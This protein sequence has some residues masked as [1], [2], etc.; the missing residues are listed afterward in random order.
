MQVVFTL[1]L[2]A[3]QA[4]CTLV[5]AVVAL[6]AVVVALFKDEFWRRFRKPKLKV[7]Y[8]FQ[9]GSISSDA[10]AYFVRLYVCNCGRTSARNVQVVLRSVNSLDS[11][12][13]A[14]QEFIPMPLSW[15]YHEDDTP[16]L[17]HIPP[18]TGA[19]CNLAQIIRPDSQTDPQLEFVIWEGRIPL[20]T[21]N[22]WGLGKYEVRVQIAG[23]NVIANP[24]PKQIAC[25][26]WNDNKTQMQG[27][28]L[29]STK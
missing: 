9:K 7:S 17:G 2:A 20:G 4:G 29:G 23:E 16:W 28:V 3:I 25:P 6:L 12:S 8:H 18:G 21:P 1:V 22:K 14:N 11:E 27:A 26:E 19:Y 15:L 24:E 13:C 10:D 5:L